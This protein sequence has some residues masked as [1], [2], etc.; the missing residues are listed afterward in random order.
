MEN[1]LR[2]L[3]AE[4]IGALCDYIGTARLLAHEYQAHAGTAEKI[5][6]CETFETLHAF[7]AWRLS[8]LLPT[9][10]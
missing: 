1:P 9:D 2:R 10:G 3:V 6:E 7:Q 8:L 5:A 4:Q